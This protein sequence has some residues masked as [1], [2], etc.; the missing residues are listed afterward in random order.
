MPGDDPV[1]F[2]GSTRA[3]ESE[4]TDAQSLIVRGP[5]LLPALPGLSDGAVYFRLAAH[6]LELLSWEFP[7]VRVLAPVLERLELNRGESGS[8]IEVVDGEIAWNGSSALVARPVFRAAPEL[9]GQWMRAKTLVYLWPYE[10]DTLPANQGPLLVQQQLKGGNLA[11]VGDSDCQVFTIEGGELGQAVEI[12]PQRLRFRFWGWPRSGVTQRY[13]LVASTQYRAQ[14]A[15]GDAVTAPRQTLAEWTDIYTINLQLPRVIPWCWWLLAAGV[16]YVAFVAAFQHLARHPDKLGLDVRLEESVASIEPA[17]AGGPV[18][19]ELHPTA[20]GMDVKL[21]ARY[22]G[23]RWEEAGRSLVPLAGPVVGKLLHC[24]ALVVAPVQVLAR[25][26]ALPRWWAWSLI[27]PKTA[28]GK[29]RAQSGLLCVWTSPFARAR[30]WSSETGAFELPEKGQAKSITLD[31]PYLMDQSRRTMRV[32]VKF[33][34]TAPEGADATSD[35][36]HGDD[37]FEFL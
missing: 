29:G 26:C 4:T 28:S 31:L 34:N 20:L 32:S 12:L 17:G 22:L 11:A 23:G 37:E 27:T 13:A 16:V 9:T 35:S 36:A 33:R 2:E 7:N 14:E 25:R 24:L 8:E 18:H 30:G 19:I 15:E 1:W 5:E 21:H 6:G 10:G 3:T